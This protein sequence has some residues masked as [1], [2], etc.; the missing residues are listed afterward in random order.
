M[1]CP[2]CNF[3]TEVRKTEPFKKARRRFRL[4]DNCKT[5]F[6][7]VETVIEGTVSEAM[8]EEVLSLVF[9]EH[10]KKELNSKFK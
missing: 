8:D 5:T 1:N 6:W 7:T 10:K 3:E 9:P 2:N 4:C